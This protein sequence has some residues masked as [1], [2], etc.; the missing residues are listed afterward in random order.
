M[1][2]PLQRNATTLCAQL[3]RRPAAIRAALEILRTELGSGKFPYAKALLLLAEKQP[4]K[5]YPHFDTVAALLRH[6]NIIIQWTAIH[7]VANLAAVDTKRRLDGLLA[8]YLKPIAGPVMITSANTIQGAARIAQARP[9]WQDKIITAILGVT[10]A[11]YQTAE[12]RHIAAGH[13]I[14]ALASLGPAAMTRPAVLRFIRRQLKNPRPATRAK[15]ARFLKQ[16]RG[17]RTG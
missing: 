12:C 7:L 9:K 2:V 11:H 17:Q 6:P 14:K 15:A 16:T 13:A 5:L 10:R 4:R 3:A 8:A 1:S